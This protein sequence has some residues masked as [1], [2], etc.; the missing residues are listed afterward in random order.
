MSRLSA[1]PLKSTL[2][3]DSV[4]K[5]IVDCLLLSF[6]IR[7]EELETARMVPNPNF[8]VIGSGE[9]ELVKAKIGPL[10]SAR[11]RGLLLILTWA[12]VYLPL[13]QI[14]DDRFRSMYLANEVTGIAERSCHV[15]IEVDVG[16]H[17]VIGR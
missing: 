4:A 16:V 11:L 13:D 17:Y 9:S 8:V 3:S 10:L 2:R 5:D 7:T 15:I 1:P 14:I 6:V 12:Y